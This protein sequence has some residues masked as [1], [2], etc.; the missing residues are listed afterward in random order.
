M[1]SFMLQAFFFLLIQEEWSFLHTVP[2]SWP[3]NYVVVEENDSYTLRCD[4]HTQNVKWLT[5][6]DDCVNSSQNALELT[7]L[8]NP[9]AGN[10]TCLTMDN[11]L[12]KSV[13][14][15]IKE[16]ED[17]KISCSMD[18]YS[19]PV[20]SCS[21]RVPFCSDCLVRAKAKTR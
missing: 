11:I 7:D 3:K 16:N 17:L 8:E 20:L 10:Y 21:V 1:N 15:L 2:V 18:S 6:S 19:S 14:L 4:P 12:L 13:Y 9:C 5:P